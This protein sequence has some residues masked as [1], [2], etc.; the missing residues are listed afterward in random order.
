MRTFLWTQTHGAPLGRRASRVRAWALLLMA[1]AIGSTL[2]ACATTKAA[3]V[4]AGPPLVVSQ[5]PPRVLVPPEEVPLVATGNG[6]DTPVVTSS[7]R[8]PPPPPPQR[9]TTPPR[10]SDSDPRT[11]TPA[12]ATAIGPNLPTEATR[13]LLEQIVV[14]NWL[15]V[16]EII[17]VW[18]T[19]TPDLTAAFPALAAREMG[20]VD[21]P[22]LC[23]SEIPVPGSM[24]R[25][26][27]TL[28]EV[29]PHAPRRL[30]T[31]VYLR[32]AVALRPDIHAEITR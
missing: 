27:R 4:V 12:A 20:W 16:D 5:P 7:P 6:P 29:E 31:H 30:D 23:A 2:S 3:P 26:L 15:E 11:E 9:R 32:D 17:S 18:F 22:L 1:G 24:A 21:V 25:C 19:V 14:R 13:E 10:A 28:I 8:L